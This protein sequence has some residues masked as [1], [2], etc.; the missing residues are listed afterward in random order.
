MAVVFIILAVILLFYLIY[1]FMAEVTVILIYLG[2]ICFAAYL[3]FNPHIIGKLWRRY[4]SDMKY[5]DEEETLDLSTKNLQELMTDLKRKMKEPTPLS[6]RGQEEYNQEIKMSTEKVHLMVDQINSLKN[7]G[8]NIADFNA[9]MVI[10]ENRFEN[11]VDNKL[12]GIDRENQYIDNQFEIEISKQKLQKEQLQ[13][14]I[15]LEKEKLEFEKVKMQKEL[16][17]EHEEIERLRADIYA[18]KTDT[19]VRDLIAKADFNLQEARTIREID[20]RGFIKDILTKID[21]TKLPVELQAYLVAC[22][23]NK[24][25]SSYDEY[26]MKEKLNSFME[27]KARAETGKTNAEAF[28]IR[29][30]AGYKSSQAENLNNQNKYETWKQ[31]ESKKNWN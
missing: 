26:A 14:E 18:I 3:A 5:S 9:E 29:T 16:E 19:D 30:D 13:K 23:F 17:R 22:V 1:V 4:V 20:E 2:L 24:N 21:P 10:H 12:K 28:K 6:L 8:V 25:T 27:M 7:A 11:F 31:D 15:S